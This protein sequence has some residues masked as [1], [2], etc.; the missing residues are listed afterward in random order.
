MPKVHDH[1]QYR[2][3]L[4]HKCFD[5]FA[6]KGY[7]TLTTRQIAQALGVS[8]GTLYYYFPSKEELFGQLIE[9][10]TQHDLL[11][12][13]AEIQQANSMEERILALGQFLLEN[14]AY[15]FKQT[16]L[17]MDFYQ[18]AGVGQ[19]RVNEAVRRASQ[20]SRQEIA[21]LLGVDDPAIATH[22]LCWIDGLISERMVDSESVSY[23]EQAELLAAMLTA[24]LERKQAQPP[25]H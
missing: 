2:K 20:R 14:E 10:L 8:T 5:L 22:V 16:L 12:A 4:L 1:D 6:E 25:N 24:Y 21:R 18:Q 3:E 13:L 23:I 17:Y 9:E 7:A 15:F 19:S 11:K